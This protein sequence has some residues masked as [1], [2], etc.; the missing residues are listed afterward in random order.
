[1]ES[2]QHDLVKA[3]E[4]AA[5]E[6]DRFFQTV[7]QEMTDAAE[8]FVELSE[9]IADQ[10][11]VAIAPELDKL[12]E[13]IDDW[14]EPMLHAI[15]MLEA[16]FTEAAEPVSRTVEPILNHHPVCTGCRHYHGQVYNDTM[17][18]C[19]MHPYGIEDGVDTC[20]DKELISWSFPHT[21]SSDGF[22]D[23]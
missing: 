10:I 12:D 3:L 5:S 19:A 9:E 2:W 18:V 7:A 14:V 11:Q 4:T 1:M 15:A 23:E 20:P 16:A 21:H 22:D 6:M 8:T 17:L 13:Q